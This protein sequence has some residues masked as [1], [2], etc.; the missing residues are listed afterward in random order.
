MLSGDMTFLAFFGHKTSKK[1]YLHHAGVFFYLSRVGTIWIE[2]KIKN[3]P[4]KIP[5]KKVW[6]LT[7]PKNVTWPL[8]S[9]PT[10]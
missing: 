9:N 2:I 3:G 8:K 7:M 5:Y 6:A 10:C 4:T 1:N